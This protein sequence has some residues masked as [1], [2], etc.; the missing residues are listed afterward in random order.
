PAVPRPAPL[1]GAVWAAPAYPA[2]AA[3][4]GR[5]VGR[6]VIGALGWCWL[7]AAGVLGSSRLGLGIVESP[8]AGWS[9]STA[10]AW[11]AVLAPLFTPEALLGA[12]VFALAAVVFG[13]VLRPG[14]IAMALRGARP[15]AGRWEAALR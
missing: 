10:V 12:G 13:L 4:R 14:H 2:V 8:P 6:A 15:W 3:A 7:L 1:P 11:H 9:L 5:A